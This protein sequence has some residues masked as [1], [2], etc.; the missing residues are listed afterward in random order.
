MSV[1][2]PFQPRVWAAVAGVLLL[3]SIIFHALIL[4]SPAVLYS[5]K[6]DVASTLVWL[7]RALLHQSATRVPSASGCRPFL[8]TWWLAAL[9]LSTSYVGNLIASLTVPTESRRIASL[10]ELAFSDLRIH[11]LDYGNFVPGYLW[12]SREPVL[13]ELGDKLTLLSEY[14]QVIDAFDKGAGVLEATEYSQY[15]FITRQRSKRAYAVEE[16]LYPNYVGWVF[17]KGSPYKYVFD[18]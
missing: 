4:P 11:M 7:S 15:L 14:D 6:G 13:R 18:K 17:Q 16:K 1:V 10:E 9:V 12:S 8:A 5:D 3:V 2:Y